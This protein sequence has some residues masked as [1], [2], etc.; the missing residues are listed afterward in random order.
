ML[1]CSVHH[2]MSQLLYYVTDLFEENLSIHQNCC[3]VP[4]YDCKLHVRYILRLVK[5]SSAQC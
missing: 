3:S 5:F 1:V 4:H 2:I